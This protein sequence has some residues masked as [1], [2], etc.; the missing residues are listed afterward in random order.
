MAFLGI[1]ISKLE[2]HAHLYE[3]KGE[4][5][6][7]FR[8]STIGFRQLSSWLRNRKVEDIHACMEA[9]GSYWEALAFYAHASPIVVSVVNPARIKAYS[10]S[11]LLRS[12]ADKVDAALIA[13]FCRAQAPAAWEPPPAEI[14]TLQ[15]FARYLQLLKGTRASHSTRLQTP[16]IPDPVIDSAQRLIRELDAEIETIESVF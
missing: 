6:R 13:R 10:R 4:A 7:S 15:G 16:L 5:K 12:K 1:D 14:R 9:T 3:A 2:F 11:E 8:N